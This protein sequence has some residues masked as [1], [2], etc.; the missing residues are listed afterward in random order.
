MSPRR[1]TRRKKKKKEGDPV[2]KWLCFYDGR[3]IFLSC[4]APIQ[5]K[6]LQLHLSFTIKKTSSSSSSSSA[7]CLLPLIVLSYRRL[8]KRRGPSAG[9]FCS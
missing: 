5:V 7:A 2:A 3:L 1:L 4:V 9:H 6:K 8:M